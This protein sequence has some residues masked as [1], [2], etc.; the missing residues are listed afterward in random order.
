MSDKKS[1]SNN[2]NTENRCYY[3]AAGKIYSVASSHV[4]LS[5][6]LSELEKTYK[7]TSPEQ[8]LVVSVKPEDVEEWDFIQ[9]Y[10]NAWQDFLASEEG[11]IEVKLVSACH[12]SIIFNNIDSKLFDNYLNE[13]KYEDNINLLDKKVEVKGT[14]IVYDYI[15]IMKL[16]QDLKSIDKLKKLS[17]LSEKM[18]MN[19]LSNKIA[20]IIACKINDESLIKLNLLEKTYKSLQSKGSTFN[21]TIEF[22]VQSE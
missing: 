18:M 12:Y 1:E 13:E 16:R 6:L 20:A 4:E 9:D 5:G 19:G 17:I 22:I 14:G 7:N 15:T 10:F 11:Y 21:E 3:S 2:L 8:C